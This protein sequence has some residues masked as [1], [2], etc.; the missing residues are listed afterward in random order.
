MTNKVTKTVKDY[1]QYMKVNEYINKDTYSYLMPSNPTCSRFYILPKIHK[2]RQNP[3]GRPI[4]S[5]NNHPTEHISEYVSDI[6]NPLVSKLPSYIKDTTDFLRKLSTLNNLPNDSLLVTLDVSSL[7]TNIPHS[8]GIQA[9]RKELNK[10]TTQQPPTETICDLIDIIL[11]N[12][13]FEFDEQ[14]YL[15]KHGTAMGTRMAPPYANLFMGDL[16]RSALDKTAYKPL[17]WWRYIDD[18]FLIWTHG[19][20]KLTDFISTLNTAHP[21]IKFTH[22]VSPTSIHF[23]DVTVSLNADNNISTDLYIK[24]T[25]KHQ[26]LLSTSAHPKHTKQSI[27]YSLALRLRRICSTDETFYLRTNE[28]LTYLTNRGYKRK[29]VRNEIRKASKVTRQNSLTNKP[30]TK[31]ARTPFVVTYHPSLSHLAPILRQHYHI[32]QDSDSC[33]EAFP[34]PPMLCNR[35]PKSLKEYLVRARLKRSSTGAPRGIIRNCGKNCITCTHIHD[36][37]TTVTFTNTGNTYDIRQQL[38]CNS[39]NVIYLI[40]CIKCITDGNNNCQY[41]G[42]TGRRVRDRLIEHRRDVL[43]KKHDKSGVAEH[44]CQPGHTV[45]DLQIIPI[46]KLHTG[47]ESVRRAKEQHFIDLANT[48]TPNGLNRTTDR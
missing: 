8:D 29:H 33:K 27:P 26:Y 25:D 17:V 10:R 19:P 3:P 11:T 37:A 45:H 28:L 20:D 48:L 34:Q 15:Q 39:N 31:T 18:I 38:D 21:T 16:E 7:Y 6:L 23:L 44:F 40:Q 4:V 42:Q 36:G 9:A 22:E 32:L 47:R 35:R 2:N 14:F 12:N 41:I 1:L 5:A 30:K 13:N 24:P 43:N 46:H